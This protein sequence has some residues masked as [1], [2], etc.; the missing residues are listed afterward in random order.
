M[1]DPTEALANLEAIAPEGWLAMAELDALMIREHIGSPY[2]LTDAKRRETL[3]AAGRLWLFVQWV[4][5]INGSA[6]VI[7]QCRP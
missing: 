1:N 2:V 3:D 5:S 6:A 7:S 4:K